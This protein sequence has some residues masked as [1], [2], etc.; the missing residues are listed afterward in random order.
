MRFNIFNLSF[1]EAMERKKYWDKKLL[2]QIKKLEKF[3]K[4]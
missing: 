4:L 2:K 1:S 3:K